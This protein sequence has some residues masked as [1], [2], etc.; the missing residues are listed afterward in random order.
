MKFFLVLLYF[1]S[2]ATIPHLLLLKKR[3]AATLAFA[4]ALS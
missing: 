1:A 2:W 3:P 4:D